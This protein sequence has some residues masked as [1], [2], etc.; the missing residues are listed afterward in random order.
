MSTMYKA[1]TND[2][3]VSVETFY[4]ES[5]SQPDSSHF[6]FAYRILIENNSENTIKLLRRHW[7]I[8]DSNGIKREVEGEG[9]IGKQPILEPEESHAYVSGCNLQTDMGR[10]H[11]TY[12][13]E[14]IADGSTFEV[15]IPQF[16]MMAPYRLN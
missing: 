9:V 7:H 1:V 10:M 2:I 15:K 3:N 13:M 16:L 12:L 5:A 11:G 8:L 4:Q 6:V 14:R